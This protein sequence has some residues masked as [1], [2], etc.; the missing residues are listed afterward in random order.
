MRA[1][2]VSKFIVSCGLGLLVLILP[3]SSIAATFECPPQDSLG[4]ALGAHSDNGTTLFCSY[5]AIPG[6]DPNDFFC[7][8]N[9][10][11]GVLV[12]D[13]DA[14]F[15]PATASIS[16]GP[17][18]T[19]TSTKP[20]PTPT[21]TPTPTPTQTPTRTPTQ[22]PT[23]TS[24]GLGLGASCVSPTDC[25]SGFCVT[26]ACCNSACIG[27]LESC[28]LPGRVG[29]CTFRSPS[30]AVSSRSLVVLG[31]ALAGLGLLA[32]RRRGRRS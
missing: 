5:P 24:S 9:D 31:V 3:G 6:E 2:K 32:L 27:P 30:P 16:S 8:Y 12:Q 25:M 7:T 10:T 13:H 21:Q 18:P 23:Q 19:N 4:F 20:T 17:T 1:L 26:G 14:G 28:T 15:C 11:T 22:T 29:L